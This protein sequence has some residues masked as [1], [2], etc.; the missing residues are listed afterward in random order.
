MWKSLIYIERKE[1]KDAEGLFY[2]KKMTYNHPS[3][4]VK[5]KKKSLERSWSFSH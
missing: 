2:V 1:K 3:R 5:E 4:R